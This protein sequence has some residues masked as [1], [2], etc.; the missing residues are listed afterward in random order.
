[1]TKTLADFKVGDTVYGEET[2]YTILTET[3]GGVMLVFMEALDESYSDFSAYTDDF[4]IEDW[5]EETSVA[6]VNSLFKNFYELAIGSL[7]TTERSPGYSKIKTSD[8]S[9]VA[10]ELEQPLELFFE[11]FDLTIEDYIEP[12]TTLPCGCPN[13]ARH[14]L[15]GCLISVQNAEMIKALSATYNTLPPTTRRHGVCLDNLLTTSGC[16]NPDCTVCNEV[17]LINMEANLQTN[18]IVVRED[19]PLR[20]TG[21]C[22]CGGYTVN[23]HSSWCP[24]HD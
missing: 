24:K 21:G 13:D 5:F 23:A 15:S 17:S 11:R 19:K 3:F 2:Q 18:D 22:E 12:D 6:E 9:F 4:Y 20:D 16:T 14:L 10:D 7:F 1:M 8:C